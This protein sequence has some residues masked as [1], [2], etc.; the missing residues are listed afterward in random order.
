MSTLRI[1]P[2]DISMAEQL[3]NIEKD[4]FADSMPAAV[5]LACNGRGDR[6]SREERYEDNMDWPFLL[7]D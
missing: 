5:S 4:L 2:A 7:Q 6:A 1:I 3:S